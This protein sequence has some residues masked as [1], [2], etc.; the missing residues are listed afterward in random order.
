MTAPPFTP[1]ELAAQ[2]DAE[3]VQA[4]IDANDF[5][6]YRRHLDALAP[7]YRDPKEG[8][9]KRMT[10]EA[11]RRT[12]RSNKFPDYATWLAEGRWQTTQTREDTP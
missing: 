1:E 7:H 2:Y 5:K 11:F 4:G 8:W 10:D 9:F 12:A 6:S 3:L